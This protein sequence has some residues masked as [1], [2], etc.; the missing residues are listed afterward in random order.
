MRLSGGLESGAAISCLMEMLSSIGLTVHKLIKGIVHSTLI[1][2]PFICYHFADVDS[3]DIFYV[4]VPRFMGGKNSCQFDAYGSHRLKCQ[5]QTNT[6]RNQQ[7]YKMWKK[8]LGEVS[9]T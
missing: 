9:I 8:V 7:Q 3:G 2:H 4:T 6:P 5:K 1:F